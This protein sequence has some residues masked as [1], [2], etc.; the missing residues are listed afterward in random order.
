VSVSSD[1]SL[2]LLRGW[3]TSPALSVIEVKTGV[4]HPV[5]LPVADD[6]E[7]VFAEWLGD[8]RLLLVGAHV[9]LGDSLGAHMS[10]VADPARSDGSRPGAVMPFDARRVALGYPDGA[11]AILDLATGG[12]RPLAQRF[13][14]CSGSRG[15]TLTWSLDAAL[16]AGVDCAGDADT[17]VRIVDVAADRTLRSVEAGAYRVSTFANGHFLVERP[18]AMTGEGAPSIGVEIKTDGTEVRRFSG[19]GRWTMSPDGRSVLQSD[20]LGGVGSSTAS[21]WRLIEQDGREFQFSIPP[22]L[23]QWLADG[24]L[25][26]VNDYR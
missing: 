17:V 24:R 11:V 5:V 2:V 13:H 22:G 4:R 20:Q 3:P 15:T 19:G 21:P 6:G 26:V 7:M 23:T 18:S 1:A 9:W 8:G 25:V 16:L 14:P 12:A 10:L